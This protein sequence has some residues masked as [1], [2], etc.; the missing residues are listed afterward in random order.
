MA[1]SGEIGQIRGLPPM[2]LI[3]QSQNW[4]GFSKNGAVCDCSSEGRS[5]L[6]GGFISGRFFGRRAIWAVGRVHFWTIFL[7]LLRVLGW[8]FW[9][10]NWLCVFINRTVCESRVSGRLRMWR[11]RCRQWPPFQSWRGNH[12]MQCG[13]VE[14][15]LRNPPIFAISP[16]IT[17]HR[18]GCRLTQSTPLPP[19]Q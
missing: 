15:L 16:K 13:M 7:A 11:A 6:L 10:C 3:L 17:T 4:S 9:F 5:G 19:S 2:D 1:K 8:D 12:Y 14:A 18:R